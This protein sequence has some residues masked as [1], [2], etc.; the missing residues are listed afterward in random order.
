[1]SFQFGSQQMHV[2]ET[3]CI[4]NLSQLFSQGTHETINKHLPHITVG[5]LLFLLSPL[6]SVVDTWPLV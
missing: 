6:Y 2:S 4:F 3:A 5:R 1:M